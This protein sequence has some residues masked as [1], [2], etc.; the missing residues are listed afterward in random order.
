MQTLHAAACMGIQGILLTLAW[1]VLCLQASTPA[2]L[3]TSDHV[4]H[5]I[6]VP[7]RVQQPHEA[8]RGLEEGRGHVPTVTPL[9]RSSGRSSSSQAQ[10]KLPLPAE[11][12]SRCALCTAFWLTCLRMHA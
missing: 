12:A 5:K 10:P 8:P 11:A 2:A 9:A 7:G 6:A 4:G 1:Q 3:L